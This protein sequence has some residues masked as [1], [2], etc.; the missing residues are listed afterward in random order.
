M[1]CKKELVIDATVED[2]EAIVGEE[3][4]IISARKRGPRHDPSYEPEKLDS[5]ENLI[6]LCRTDHKIV[7]DQAAT[8]TTEILR[9]MKKTHEVW[10]SQRLTC[11]WETTA[12]PCSCGKRGSCL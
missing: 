11:R 12:D 4:H 6:L 1:F 8:F 5:C 7:D 2:A 10:V 3:C 9:Q